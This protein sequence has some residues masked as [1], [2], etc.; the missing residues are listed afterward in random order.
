MK[1][2]FLAFF[3]IALIGLGVMTF[4]GYDSSATGQGTRII[5]PKEVAKKITEEVKKDAPSKQTNKCECEN[6]YEGKIVVDKSGFFTGLTKFD[7]SLYREIYLLRKELQLKTSDL[8]MAK[9]FCK[10]YSWW[11]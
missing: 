5:I 8:E 6:P 7:C 2:P 1:G 11:D 10:T 4:A 3:F 9:T